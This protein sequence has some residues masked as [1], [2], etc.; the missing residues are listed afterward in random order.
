LSS[1]STT[2]RGSL[3]SREYFATV[4]SSL[5]PFICMAPSPSSANT[6]RSG[7]AGSAPPIDSSVPD[8]LASMPGRTCR[9]RAYQAVT[10]PH[11]HEA[12]VRAP[13]ER[14][15][16][17]V[18]PVTGVAEVPRHSPRRQ[19]VDDVVGDRGVA[20]LVS[21]RRRLG[22]GVGGHPDS[23]ASG[24]AAGIGRMS[25]LRAPTAG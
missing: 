22:R 3:H 4:I 9:C 5:T 25:I 6:G 13:L 1:T 23:L 8:R 14:G 2:N 20:R 21:G 15:R 12:R 18:D 19:A 16:H 11:L 10:M 17:A 24:A 7:W